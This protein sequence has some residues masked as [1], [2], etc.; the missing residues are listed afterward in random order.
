R[1]QDELAR[2]Y[3][4]RATIYS[5]GTVVLDRMINTANLREAFGDEAIDT[6]D[7]RRAKAGL[8][9]SSAK[10]RVDEAVR[11]LNAELNEESPIRTVIFQ[12]RADVAAN[13]LPQIALQLQL[14]D[15]DLNSTIEA[16]RQLAQSDALASS[17]SER[18]VQLIGEGRFDELPMLMNEIEQLQS[19]LER[20][21]ASLDQQLGTDI[22]NL[23]DDQLTEIA[24][25]VGK[26][27]IAMSGQV[28]KTSEEEGLSPVEI[29]MDD[30]MMT[31]L[32]QRFDL[33]NERGFVG[34]RW[35][36]IKYAADDLKSVLNLRATQSIR[37][38]NGVNRP[39]DFSF[40]DST[41]T[42]SGTF[43]APFN[44]RQQRNAYRQS[45][46]NYQASL[47]RLTQ[48]EDTI[49]L[50]VRRDIRSIALQR[51]QYSNDIAS[52]ALAY[53]RVVS[54]EL[55]LRLGVGNVAA[56]DFLEAQTAYISALSNVA[57][58]H[59][60]YIVDRMQLFLDLESLTV[61]DDGFW[62]ELYD[63]TYQPEP[64]F[65]LPGYALPAFG[66]LHPCLKYSKQIRCLECAPSGVAMNHR[67]DDSDSNV[68]MLLHPEP[69]MSEDIEPI[70]AE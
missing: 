33:I 15:P 63:E 44:R 67:D 52:A 61:G 60:D 32:V 41:T 9:I 55:E 27:L 31:A 49:K 42:V 59:I 40:D 37:T 7:W 66:C 6:T 39:F 30:A 21:V 22:S 65:Q 57:S 43:D 10:I 48:L 62:H 29:D 18:F 69:D 64:F 36:R 46:F 23:T 28:L 25:E 3:P 19:R 53:E 17:L 50:G 5:A 12:R 51:E 56:R 38:P 26:E 68:E 34:D 20:E 1:I 58:R 24:V 13:L 2:E 45:L 11:E 54:T 70:L 14:L 4:T 47:R 8:Q 16:Q 35:R